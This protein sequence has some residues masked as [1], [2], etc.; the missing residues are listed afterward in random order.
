MANRDDRVSDPQDR[1]TPHGGTPRRRRGSAPGGVRSETATAGQVQTAGTTAGGARPTGS[2]SGSGAGG[3]DA[4]EGEPAKP[5]L[6]PEL[7]QNLERFRAAV[8][9]SNRAARTAEAYYRDVRIFFEWL[10]ASGTGVQRVSEIRPIH[11]L[12]YRVAMVKDNLKLSTRTRRES[13]LRLFFKLMVEIGL[14]RAQDNPMV[15]RSAFQPRARG[16]QRALP[17]FLSEG[18]AREFVR[19]ILERE[20]AQG[21][22]QSWMKARDAALFTLLLTMGLRVSELC[23]LRLRHA[24]EML[25]LGFCTIRGK[26]DKERVVPVPPTAAQRLQTYLRQRPAVF[27][28]GHPLEGQRVSDALFLSK[29]LTPIGPRG[30]QFLIKTYA[31]RAGFSADLVRSL[32][33]HKLRHTFAT[34][35]LEGGANLRAI[36]DLLGH[37][38]ISTT[39]I[40]THVRRENLRETIR[41]LPQI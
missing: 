34:L 5:P 39:Q 27:P 41:R 38:H 23:S 8:T 15:E 25:R 6:P 28:A 9:G 4:G 33:P 7:D 14:I 22:R 20:D 17:V 30:V 3:P 1:G 19:T 11:I 36:Q 21:G 40:Y 16:G 35:L 12:D 26:G 13:A 24:E 10:V 37:A 2:A 29:D 32:T 18:Q 31:K